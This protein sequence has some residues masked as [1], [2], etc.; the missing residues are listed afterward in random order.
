MWEIKLLR[1]TQHFNWWKYIC[2]VDLAFS[3]LLISLLLR[4]FLFYRKH[5]NVIFVFLQF[6]TGIYNGC[7]LP[8]DMGRQKIKI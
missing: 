1:S 5:A 4:D 7:L 6:N 8:S 2:V 3:L